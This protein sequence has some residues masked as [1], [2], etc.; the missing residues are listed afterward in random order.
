MQA[1]VTR[2]EQIREENEVV[3][4]DRLTKLDEYW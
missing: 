4:D 3:L 1:M 2:I